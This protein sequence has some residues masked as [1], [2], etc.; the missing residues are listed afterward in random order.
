MKATLLGSGEPLGMPVP[1]CGCEY[2]ENGPERLRAGL[3][4]K[5]DGK[6]LVFDIGPDIR[7]QLIET[8]VETVD[9][10]FSTHCHFDHFGGLPE[11]HNLE[12][13]TDAEISLYGAEA[14]ENYIEEVYSWI[15]IEVE[16]SDKVELEEVTVEGFE[17]EHSEFL[18]MQGFAATHQGKKN[19]LHS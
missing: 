14:V 8:G 11:L 15:D 16:R 5:A 17:V 3:L 7:R 13:F 12:K 18:P 2:C 9:G 10:F 4:V 6:T 1:M 19:S